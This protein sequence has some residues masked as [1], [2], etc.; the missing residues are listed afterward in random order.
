MEQIE[1]IYQNKL[2]TPSDINEH[3]PILRHYASMSETI[4]EFG[5]RAVVSTWALLAGKPKKL[6]RYD[7]NDC[8]ISVVKALASEIGV[9]F[10]FIQRNTLDVWIPDTDLLFIDTWHTCDQLLQLLK[11]N[12]QVKK[13]III[14]DTHSCGEVGEKLIPDSKEYKGLNYDAIKEFLRI[15]PEEWVVDKVFTNNNGLTILK[16]I[17]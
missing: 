4:V 14:H 5:N 8:D 7:I 6:V 17:K 16:S 10:Q 2:N 15:Y 11:H 13:Y 1:L 9:H 12:E 3:L